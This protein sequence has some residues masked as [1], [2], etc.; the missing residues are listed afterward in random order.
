MCVNTSRVAFL[1]APIAAYR[2]RTP[3]RRLLRKSRAASFASHRSQLESVRPS[4]AAASCQSSRSSLLARKLICS[5]FGG[6]L[7]IV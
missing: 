5:L 4:A 7:D 2:V 3:S 6:M 1:S